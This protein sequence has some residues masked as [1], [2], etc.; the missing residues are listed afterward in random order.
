MSLINVLSISFSLNCI[1]PASGGL[2]VEINSSPR[3]T[4]GD[5]RYSHRMLMAIRSV[6]WAKRGGIPKIPIRSTFSLPSHRFR[7][8]QSESCHADLSPRRS[9]DTVG[10]RFPPFS[11]RAN[12]HTRGIQ[13]TPNRAVLCAGWKVSIYRRLYRLEPRARPCTRGSVLNFKGSVGGSSKRF[14]D[15]WWTR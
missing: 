1:G 3:Q 15:Y 8:F 13:V 2:N 11:I 5:S 9:L 4:R 7:S 6:C 14:C 10:H 12:K